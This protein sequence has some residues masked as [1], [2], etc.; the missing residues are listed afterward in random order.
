MSVFMRIL[1][2]A[3]LL[4]GALVC[5]QAGFQTG[6]FVLVILGMALE[7]GFWLGIYKWERAKAGPSNRQ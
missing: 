2:L 4:T 7:F 1:L 6:V 3:A 5:Y